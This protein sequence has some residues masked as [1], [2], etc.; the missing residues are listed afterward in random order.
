MKKTLQR[1]TLFL[2]TCV[3]IL[4]VQTNAG[5]PGAG[6]TNA[7]S[8]SSCAQSGCHGGSLVTSGSKHDKIKLITSFTG[9]G[10]LPDSNYTIY[11]TYKESGSDN[12]WGFQ[13]TALSAATNDMAGTFT[14]PDSRTQDYASYSAGGKTRNSIGHTS[15]GTSSV[16]TDSVAWKISW[17][18]PSSNMGNITFYLV[19]NVTDAN[20]QS[21]NDIIYAKQFTVTPSSLLPVAKFKITES[22]YCSN[23]P[24][25]FDASASTG[26]PTSYSWRFKPPTGSDIIPLPQSTAKYTTSFGATGTYKAILTVKNNK[27][28]SKP[29]TLTFSV[30]QGASLS[31]PIPEGT[32]NICKGDSLVITASNLAGHTYEWSP[33]GQTT[34]IIKVADSSIYIVTSI[35]SNG[36]RRKSSKSTV[37]I[38]NDLPTVNVLKSFS[39]DT[40]CAGTP[41]SLGALVTAGSADSFSFISRNGPYSKSDT[42]NRTV[43]SGPASFSVWGKSSKGCK[44]IG[45]SLTIQV[46]QPESAPVLTSSNVDYTGFRVNWGT[47]TSATGYMVS[48]DS[49]KSFITPS[50]GSNGL[51]HDVSGLLG[52]HTM[53]VLVYATTNGHCSASETSEIQ[54]TTLS[55]TPLQFS[56]SVV[57]KDKVCK[58]GQVQVALGQL[59]GKN[60]NVKIDGVNMG[61]DTIQ[62]ITV[63]GTRDY[64]ISVLDSAALICGYTTIT[65]KLFEDTVAAP[66][67]SPA[68]SVNLCSVVSTQALKVTVANHSTIDS[69]IYFQNG[70][71]VATLKEKELFYGSVKTGD[72]LWTV[73]KNAS[74]CLST[75]SAKVYPTVNLFPNAGFN[76]ANTQFNYTFTATDANG[77][78][79]WRVGA[80]SSDGN[81]LAIDLTTFKNDSVTVTHYLVKNGCRS[82]QS[83]IVHVPDFAGVKINS[84]PGAK[85]Y[86]NPA[87]DKLYVYLPKADTK[88]TLEMYNTAGSLVLSAVLQKGTNEVITETMSSGTYMFRVKAGNKETT[89]SIIIER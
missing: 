36:C 37:V 84:I 45:S 54:V 48:V 13:M 60:I 34:R 82:T 43:N 16:T 58:N 70:T 63:N 83:M 28:V 17:K 79:S 33:Q 65:R 86:P 22:L 50:S 88:T 23:A 24:L 20:S 1:T 55:C 29:D 68:G 4:V 18:A 78:H 38:V 41:F 67:I 6:Y 14:N 52:N 3:V 44:S 2:L 87:A 35:A 5:G 7:P 15:T 61:S 49:G 73:V 32:V 40:I 80:D 30:I 74:G 47:V 19:L 46:E 21:T 12:K 26:S 85:I 11:V 51:F 8:E 71:R 57:G 25:T 66:S 77:T 31:T 72:S 9:G 53:K 76:S 89:G 27:G 39:G 64:D 59:A 62:N 56:V 10:Y 75:P 81:P 69:V 42:V